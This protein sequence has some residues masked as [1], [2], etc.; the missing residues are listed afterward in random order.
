MHLERVQKRFDVEC[1]PSGITDDVV[2]HDDV[3]AGRHPDPWRP[4][5]SKNFLYTCALRVGV[6]LFSGAVPEKPKYTKS[7][8]HVCDL[9]VAD[10]EPLDA[11]D[12]DAV[13]RFEISAVLR[14]LLVVRAVDAEALDD[15]VGAALQVDAGPGACL[16]IRRVA[17]DCTDQRAPRPLIVRRALAF[18][19][20]RCFGAV[21]TTARERCSVP[22]GSDCNHA[23]SGRSRRP[24]RSRR[25]TWA[26]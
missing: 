16:R 1:G 3:R 4:E 18:E 15:D 9:R 5:Y 14:T 23:R 2:L 26:R 13:L 6:R 22:A 25:S 7:T 21:A 20:D 8:E 12:V 24:C 19:L 11:S 17:G 10:D